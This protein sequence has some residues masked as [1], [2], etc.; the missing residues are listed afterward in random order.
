MAS[1]AAGI[2]DGVGNDRPFPGGC[3]MIRKSIVALGLFA[4]CLTA[5]VRA[6]PVRVEARPVQSV[7]VTSSAPQRTTI[8]ISI[9]GIVPPPTTT[10]VQKAPL[11]L[12]LVLD[13]SGSM[14]GEKIDNMR[15]AALDILERMGPQDVL[16]VVSFDDAIDVILP[17]TR[18]TDPAA[19]RSRILALQP[20]GMTALFGGVSQGLAQARKFKGEGRSTRVVLVSDGQANVGP[21]SVSELAALGRSA[22]KEGISVST[23]GLG[24]GYNEDLMQQLALNSDGN[25]DF[26]QH[27]MDLTRIFDRE[28]GDAQEIVA[29]DLDIRFRCPEGVRPVRVLDREARIAGQ[30]LS[31]RWNQVAGGQKKILLVEVEVPA[32]KAGTRLDL[33]AATVSVKER[34]TGAVSSLSASAAVTYS[35]DRVEAKASVDRTTKAAVVRATANEALKQAIALRD[36]GQRA[37]AKAALQR[38]AIMLDSAAV[39]LGDDK[40]REDAALSQQ[41]AQKVESEAEW[42]SSRKSLRSKQHKITTQSKE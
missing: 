31:V 12:S 35:A 2:L 18:V 33:G 5:P 10:A 9:E 22:G 28:F 17:A 29:T 6:A 32:G 42:G 11:N 23:V 39:E 41:A 7:L 26:A 30:E 4:T 36:R 8:Q 25:H 16:S 37:E 13:R 24:E 21:S 27:P 34:S 40:L 1:P 14:S 19:L 38:N 15:R 3:T 20:G